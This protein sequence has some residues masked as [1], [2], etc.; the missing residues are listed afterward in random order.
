MRKLFSA[1]MICVLAAG[2]AACGQKAPEA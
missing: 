1:A 2:L